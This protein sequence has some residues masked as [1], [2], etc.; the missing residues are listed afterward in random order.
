VF[1]SI[2]KFVYYDKWDW[3]IQWL[4]YIIDY[5]ILYDFS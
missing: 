4:Y 3:R 5:V 1:L 2:A